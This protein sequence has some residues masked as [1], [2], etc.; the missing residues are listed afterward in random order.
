MAEAVATSRQ[1][2]ERMR[3]DAR[4]PPEIVPTRET[5]GPQPRSILL[6]GGTGFL[7]RYLLRELLASSDRQLFCLVRAADDESARSRLL[8]AL[9]AA[10]AG[11]VGLP[12]AIRVIPAAACPGSNPDSRRAAGSLRR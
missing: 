9:N 1:V 12:A 8:S 4:L 6:T 11:L 10:G 7:G 3:R 5:A 2:G